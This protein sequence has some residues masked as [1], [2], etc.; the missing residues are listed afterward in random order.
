MILHMICLLVLYDKILL[1]STCSLHYL[2][3]KQAIGIDIMDHGGTQLHI[4]INQITFCIVRSIAFWTDVLQIKFKPP[5][6][7]FC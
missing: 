4:T 6:D 3:R 2:F 1:R 7:K 5:R